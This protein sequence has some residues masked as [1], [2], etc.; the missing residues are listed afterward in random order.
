MSLL[1]IIIGIV[2]VGVLLWLINNYIPMEPRIKNL[3]NIVV[4]VLLAVWLLH[5]LGLFGYLREIRV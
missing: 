3:L 2:L 5:G 4:I 1:A